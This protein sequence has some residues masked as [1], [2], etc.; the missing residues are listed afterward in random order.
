MLAE[1][2]AKLCYTRQHITAD[3]QLHSNNCKRYLYKSY[4]VG[5]EISGA[6]K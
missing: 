3:S 6:D 5:A 1:A 4:I 2:R